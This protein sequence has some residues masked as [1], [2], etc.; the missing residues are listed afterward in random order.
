[1]IG[2]LDK[3]ETRL[4]EEWETFCE[5]MK[6]EL[7]QDTAESAKREAGRRLYRWAEVSLIPIRP[8]VDEPFVTRG[9]YQ[10]LADDL[11]VGWH[12]E[13]LERLDKILE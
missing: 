9:T 5:Q 12:P 1:M 10:M 8:R 4:I 2:E 13:F 6:D 11:R 7:G 3:Y